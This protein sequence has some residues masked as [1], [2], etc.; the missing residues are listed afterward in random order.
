M[1]GLTLAAC[2]LSTA[3]LLGQ[4]T[5][6]ATMEA[7]PCPPASGIAVQVLGSGGPVAD[8]ERA[9]SA[10]LVW[11]DGSARVLVDAGSGAFL[12]F[13]EAGARFEDLDLV[14][15]S[16]FHTDHSGDL[17]ALLKSGYFSDRRRP[18]SISGP[19]GQGAFPDLER[20]LD[21]LV[22]PGGAYAYLSGYLD[23]TDGLVRLQPVTASH[24]DGVSTEIFRND[25]ATIVAQ[26]VPHG[27]V[28]SWADRIEAGGKVLVFASDQNGTD[29]Q[30]AV[31]ARNANL[32]IA[33][34]AVPESAGGAAVRLH[35]KPS[36]IGNL[37][38]KAG[39]E[40]VVL[41]HFMARSLRSLEE[42]V[43]TV[44]DHFPGDV[45]VAEDLACFLP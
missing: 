34:L 41:S 15:L 32:L 20:W 43:A 2:S 45:T 23:G 9:S 38:R 40:R 13:G 42:Q 11:L 5:G 6:F 1:R 22:G 31:F 8:D 30:F 14:A 7:P 12:R 16:H 17:P 21:A 18:L 19:D 4:S 26:G 28:P 39:V 35:A 24:E 44:R 37:A 29:D 10:Y 36:V 25:R 27:I 3:L 33:H